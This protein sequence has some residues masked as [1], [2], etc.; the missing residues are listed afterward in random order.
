VEEESFPGSQLRIEQLSA[1]FKQID[2]NCQKLI[3]IHYLDGLKDK[4][5][6]EKSLTQYTTRDALKNH[7][8][9]CMKKLTALAKAL[10]KTSA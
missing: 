4:E 5:V 7:R 1:L 2:E 10:K 9:K 6:I 3:Q 8:A